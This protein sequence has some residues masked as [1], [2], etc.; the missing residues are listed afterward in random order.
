MSLN[1]AAS[2]DCFSERNLWSSSYSDLPLESHLIT[3]YKSRCVLCVHFLI[4]LQNVAKFCN[5]P[6]KTFFVQ[7][8]DKNI[9]T[10]RHVSMD[11]A[12]CRLTFRSNL[13][14]PSNETRRLSSHGSHCL[15]IIA[16]QNDQFS[17]PEM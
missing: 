12:L 1:H 11:H 4:E 15:Y 13:F 2:G 8:M 5:A 9:L 14:D 17:F 6:C 16:T 7:K 10:S 3:V